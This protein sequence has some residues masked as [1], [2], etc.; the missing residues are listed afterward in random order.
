MVPKKTLFDS[1]SLVIFSVGVVFQSFDFTDCTHCLSLPLSSVDALSSLYILS[2]FLRGFPPSCGE[3]SRSK[4]RWLVHGAR[5][6][7]TQ[8]GVLSSREAPLLI[9]Q[10]WMLPALPELCSGCGGGGRPP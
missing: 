9:P 2:S 4:E 10:F 1:F 6:Q 7:A 8:L 5:M 3:G